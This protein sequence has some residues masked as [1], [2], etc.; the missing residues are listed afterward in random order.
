C[1]HFAA[2]HFRRSSSERCLPLEFSVPS[3]A[4]TPFAAQGATLAT[5]DDDMTQGIPDRVLPLRR[6]PYGSN[7]FSGRPRIQINHAR[8]AGYLLNMQDESIVSHVCSGG[9]KR[10]PSATRRLSPSTTSSWMGGMCVPC[11]CCRRRQ[12]AKFEAMSAAVC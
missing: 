5:V 12:A 8:Q 2:H 11:T 9:G 1:C 7:R 10:K 3:L 4:C 6:P